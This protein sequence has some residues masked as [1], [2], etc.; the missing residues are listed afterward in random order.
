MLHFGA[1]CF[2]TL[3]CLLLAEIPSPQACVAQLSRC[4]AHF[5]ATLLCPHEQPMTQN[6]LLASANQYHSSALFCFL[7][8]KSLALSFLSLDYR[9]SLSLS[10][11]LSLSLSLSVCVCVYVRVCVSILSEMVPGHLL[12]STEINLFEHTCTTPPCTITQIHCPTAGPRGWY[13]RL[14]SGA[15]LP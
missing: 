4:A 10:R 13:V 11:S 7:R 14:Q 15:A 3:H 5:P 2:W 6:R 9:P 12:A 1:D 8:D